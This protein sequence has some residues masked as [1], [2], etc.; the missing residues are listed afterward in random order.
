MTRSIVVTAA[1]VNVQTAQ[2]VG[3]KR[4]LTFTHPDENESMNW[5]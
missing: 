1:N 3:F 2:T 5:H 4:H